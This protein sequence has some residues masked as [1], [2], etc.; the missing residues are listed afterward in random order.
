[1][2]IREKK[3]LEFIAKQERQHS[4]VRMYES[5]TPMGSS[6]LNRE[7]YLSSL[8][9]KDRDN[10][11]FL[12]NEIFPDRL[13]RSGSFALFAVGTTTYGE[14][15]WSGLANY[16]KDKDPKKL[17]FV[18]RHGEDIDL[19]I[20][21]EDEMF[22]ESTIHSAFEVIQR[23]LNKNNLNFKVE[24]DKSECGT[25]YI[26]FRKDQGD[27]SSPLIV[28]RYKR[29]EY[30]SRKIKVDIPNSRPFHIFFDNSLSVENKL[31]VERTH[32]DHPFSLLFRHNNYSDFRQ[33]V[34]LINAYEN[35][36][37]LIRQKD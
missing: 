14:D 37:N 24:D 2:D 30:G 6:E 31:K 3:R 10:L 25:E 26:H 20:C 22:R 9:R 4:L 27:I 35:Q 11:Y 1:M 34:N 13:C 21:S 18:Q 29:I 19:Q 8:P 36:R 16:L 17:E 28:E 5:S 23:V 33:S 12:V 32:D 15:Y 7:K